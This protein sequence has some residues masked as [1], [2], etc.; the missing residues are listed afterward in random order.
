MNNFP[1]QLLRTFCPP[2]LLEEIEG[3]LVQRYE[4]DV[5]T[6]GERRAKRKLLWN[7]IRFCRPSI[8]LRRKI[9]V[10]LNFGFMMKNY[11]KT[12]VRHVAKDKLNFAFKV[13]GLTLAFF[14]F[15]AIA[16]YISFQFSFDKFH[17]NYKNI[18]RVNSLRTEN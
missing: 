16:I 15:M 18:Y 9:I 10:E 5:K 8:V 3:D 17:V 13:S 4:R 11:F 6:F 1:Y 12:T 7:V 14:S 2:H